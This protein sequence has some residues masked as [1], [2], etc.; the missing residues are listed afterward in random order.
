MP[1]PV[2]SAVVFLCFLQASVTYADVHCVLAVQL[3]NKDFEWP[4]TI[5]VTLL[6]QGLLLKKTNVIGRVF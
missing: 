6:L 5:L 1:P 3:T 4:S 2:V